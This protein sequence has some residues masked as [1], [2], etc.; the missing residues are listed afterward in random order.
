MFFFV[1]QACV[2]LPIDEMQMWPVI[3]TEA[4]RRLSKIAEYI[5]VHLHIETVLP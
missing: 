5:M 1:A 2:N 4:Q 3:C